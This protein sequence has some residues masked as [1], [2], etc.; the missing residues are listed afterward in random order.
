MNRPLLDNLQNDVYAHR[1]HFEHEDNK[2][3]INERVDERHPY[4]FPRE[5]L[6]NYQD[7]HENVPLRLNENRHIPMDNYHHR[8][9]NRYYGVHNAQPR[10]IGLPERHQLEDSK[11]EIR[12]QRYRYNREPHNANVQQKYRAQFEDRKYGQD[13]NIPARPFEYRNNYQQRL[14][15]QEDRFRI[16]ENEF[17]PHRYYR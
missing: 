15:A 8:Y 4:Y 16:P 11:R 10:D 6:I 1:R 13:R 5:R 7:R 14:P 9:Q 3:E 2:R 17:D 12:Q